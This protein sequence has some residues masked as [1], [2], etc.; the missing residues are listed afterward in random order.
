MRAGELPHVAVDDVQ[1]QGDH[2]GDQSELEREN[3][4]VTN[5]GPH[6]ESQVKKTEMDG[7]RDHHGKPEKL[8]RQFVGYGSTEPRYNAYG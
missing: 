2:D 4:V 8:S 6:M 3:S 7:H 5:P 1:A